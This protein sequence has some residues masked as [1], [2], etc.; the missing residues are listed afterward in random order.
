M[1]ILLEYPWPGNVRELE[2][3][4]EFAIVRCGQ[5]TIQ[6]EDLPPELHQQDL[7]VE[8]SGLDEGPVDEKEQLMAALH[9]TQGN[10]TAAARLLGISRA[11]LYRRLSNCGLAAASPHPERVRRSR[12]EA[13]RPVSYKQ[14]P[15][16]FSKAFRLA[17]AKS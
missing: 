13:S 14:R 17:R 16:P 6:P 10:R 3:A 2:N 4:I 15:E 8:N 12:D 9:Q 5:G 11:T 7:A 1:R